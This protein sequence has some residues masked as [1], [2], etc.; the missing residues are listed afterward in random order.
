MRN[1]LPIGRRGGPKTGTRTLLVCTA[2]G[3]LLA[4]VLHDPGR[5]VGGHP[6]AAPALSPTAPV[7]TTTSAAP[8]PP[9]PD[10]CVAKVASLS[11]R[12]RLAQL[13]M[14]GVDP[15]GTADALALV[16]GEQVGGIFIGG[17]DTGLLSGGLDA[18]RGAATVPLQVAVD[19]EGGRVQ[20]VDVLDGSIPSAREMAAAMSP[21]QV[22][23]LARDRATALKNR[24]VSMDLAP[25]VD[26]SGQA[27]ST[28]IGD[29]SFS[30]DPAVAAQYALAF[31][32]GLHEVGTTPVLKHFPGHGNTSG[33]SHRGAVTSPPLEVLRRTDLV[34]Y[35]DI[36]RYGRVV[37]MLGHIDVPGLTNG[38]PAT[39]SPEAYALLRGEFGFTG[40]AM[41]DDLGAMRAVTDRVDLPE[42]VRQALAAGADI[43]LWSTGGRTGEV[44]DHLEAAVATGTL[45]A[46]RVD[47]AAR[48]V[49]SL[50]NAC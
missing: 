27:D 23:V 42:A 6:V 46:T 7:T 1:E 26:T 45:P 5:E 38:L 16:R 11:A 48:R 31:A 3:A 14:V 30:A 32:E 41:T 50:K 35:R 10:P 19:D 40:P 25:V 29:R 8:P 18:V 22:R 24:G 49:L 37:V 12:H 4:A 44:L 47:E 9:P 17:D 34:P 43:A 2:L 20:R 21:D 36:D 15:R 13:L 33:D 28:V 39:L